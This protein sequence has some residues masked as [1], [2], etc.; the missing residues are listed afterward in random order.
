VGQC[1][2]PRVFT[3]ANDPGR[4]PA[5]G[6]NRLSTKSFGSKR[7]TGQSFRR[8]PLLVCGL[9]KAQRAIPFRLVCASIAVIMISG[10]VLA[11]CTTYETPPPAPPPSPF[12][13]AWNAALGA[14]QDEGV[15]V[16][17]AD[18]GSGVIRGS[19]DQQE[20]TI[21]MQT[22][23]DGSVR[24]EMSA[25]GPKGADPGLADRISRAYDRRMGR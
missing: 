5:K 24:V 10:W 25:R 14:A 3:S 19:R 4:T 23:A 22:Q 20:V 9:L 15:R 12:D 2:Y 8:E 21:N 6:C 18:R 13:R 17:S 16:T 1:Y 7:D 11:G